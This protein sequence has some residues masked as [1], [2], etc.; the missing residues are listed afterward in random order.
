MTKDNFSTSETSVS[1]RLK[2]LIKASQ[3]LAEIESTQIINL[4]NQRVGTVG[5]HKEFVATSKLYRLLSEFG[6]FEDSQ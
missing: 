5:I 1:K 2:K 3:F 6:L 4:A